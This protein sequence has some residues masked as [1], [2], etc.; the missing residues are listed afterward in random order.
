[1]ISSE[2]DAAPR[3][4]ADQLSDLSQRF[5]QEPYN[6]NASH[7][8]SSQKVYKQ[9]M[10]KLTPAAYKSNTMKRYGQGVDSRTDVN[11]VAIT[12]K[13]SHQQ[14]YSKTVKMQAA[15]QKKALQKDQRSMLEPQFDHGVRHAHEMQYPTNGSR[16]TLKAAVGSNGYPV[17]LQSRAEMDLQ[18][19]DL[20][21]KIRGFDKQNQEAF[22][23]LRDQATQ[24]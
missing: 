10:S 11:S 4:L 1:M 18:L 17:A 23:E 15:T 21:Y 14:S 20:E 8:T 16:E 3:S 7:E 9:S 24:L 22:N 12:A 13:P 5:D 2:V 19:R 6:H